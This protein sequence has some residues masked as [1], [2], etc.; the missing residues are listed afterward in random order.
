MEL[1]KVYGMEDLNTFPSGTWGIKEPGLQWQ[2]GN[3]LN[4]P[5]SII[6]WESTTRRL[7]G[8][9][10]LDRDCETLDMILLPGLLFIHVQHAE[11]QSA[12][13]RPRI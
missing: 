4:G 2:G 11:L 13:Y 5:S 12:A 7:N 8:Y 6:V 3:R 9:V 1:L 10:V